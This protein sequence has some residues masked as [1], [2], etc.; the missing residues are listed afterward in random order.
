[1]IALAERLERLAMK[2]ATARISITPETANCWAQALRAYAARPNDND[3]LA[4][5]CGNKNC[6]IRSTC[7]NSRGKANLIV[8]IF[9]GRADFSMGLKRER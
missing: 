7:M 1:M 9:E 6:A 4:A 2:R 5:I 3:V 8:Q